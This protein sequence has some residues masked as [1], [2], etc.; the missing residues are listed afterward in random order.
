[1]C[2]ALKTRLVDSLY[3]PTSALN[4]SLQMILASVSA[5]Q[6]DPCTSWQTCSLWR[7]E[8]EELN[9]V[10]SATFWSGLTCHNGNGRVK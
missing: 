7:I 9:I 5:S 1:M 8:S 2:M 4:L 6:P 10:T 3:P